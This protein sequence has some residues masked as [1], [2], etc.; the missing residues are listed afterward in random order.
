M[1]FIPSLPVIIFIFIFG[2]VVFS[3]TP[4]PTPNS[5]EIDDVVKISTTLIQIDATVLDKNGKIVTGLSA[6]DFE[7]YENG[8]QQQISNFSFVELQPDK[9]PEAP[10]VKKDKNSVPV[11]PVPGRLRPDQVRRTV[12]LV[13]DDLGLSFRS[14]FSVKAALKKFVAEQ[15]QPND[16]VTIIRTSA[17][18][19]ALQQFTSDKRMLYASIERIRWYGLGRADVGV[20]QTV[21]PSDAPSSSQL[22]QLKQDTFTVGTLGA[23][24]YVIRGM[25]ELPGRK[26]VLLFSDGFKLTETTSIADDKQVRG[27]VS[28]RLMVAFRRLVDLANRSSVIIYG[29][30]ARG[31]VVAMPGADDGVGGTGGGGKFEMSAGRSAGEVSEERQGL[32]FD[33]QQGLKYIAE[34]TGGF[35]LINNNNLSKGVER[36]LNDQK[37][38]YLLGYQPDDE[39]FDPKKARFN[40][41]TVKLKRPE[42]SVRYRSGFFGIK[43]EEKR[44]VASTPR[45]QILAALT[46]PLNFGDIDLRLTS[47]FANDEQT[48]D[49]VRTIVYVKGG[50]LK[51]TAEKDGWH[52]STFDVVAMIFGDDGTPVD[53]ISRAETIRV[54][55]ATLQE[56][57][58][59]GFVSTI[60]IPIKKAGGYQMRVVIR[61]SETARVGSASQFIEVPKLNKSRLGLSGILLQRLQLQ[62]SKETTPAT[63]QFQSDEERDVA[64]RSFRAGMTVRFGYGIYNA[65]TAKAIKT[66]RLTMQYRIFHD[67]Q[68]IFASQEKDVVATEQSDARHLIAEGRFLL[69]KTIR[70]GDYVLQVIVRDLSVKESRQIATQWIDFEVTP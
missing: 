60:T 57:R 66:P 22:E 5:A 27:N 23:V 44:A 65:G 17:G 30:D 53:E 8:K 63:K 10:I 36:V 3:Q 59:K 32:L 2:S 52:K 40:K 39:T 49:F 38:Y 70:P 69:N 37:G 58:E 20:F 68:Q 19:G 50:D 6:D 16:L 67:G 15:M 46:S 34:Q 33:T 1:K 54:R 24:S 26:A 9:S 28:N 7:I 41:L 64:T 35:A 18:S 48:G 14:M 61:D 43:D 31:L 51:F 13:V 55:D 11:P 42:L 29:I 25:G 56:I 62:N 4:T 45:Q 12:A 21:D 47:L